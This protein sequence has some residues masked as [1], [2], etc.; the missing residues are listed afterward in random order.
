MRT[1]D[2]LIGSPMSI[3]EPLACKEGLPLATSCRDSLLVY[4]RCDPSAPNNVCRLQTLRSQEH[5]HVNFSPMPILH[6]GNLVPISIVE[7]GMKLKGKGDGVEARSLRMP[8]IDLFCLGVPSFIF[9]RHFWVCLDSFKMTIGQVHQRQ[10][11]L[12]T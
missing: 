11:P 8:S 2:R 7:V 5:G 9:S 4:T 3:M 10:F 6:L 1:W 12:F